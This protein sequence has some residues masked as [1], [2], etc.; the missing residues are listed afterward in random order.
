MKENKIIT[1]IIIIVILFLLITIKY[2]YLNKKNCDI[3]DREFITFSNLFG[4]SRDDHGH[5]VIQTSDGGYI[6]VGETKSFNSRGYDI[7]LIK[8]DDLGKIG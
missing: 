2:H 6:I 3:T 5:S 8:T 4:G 1:I 7:W